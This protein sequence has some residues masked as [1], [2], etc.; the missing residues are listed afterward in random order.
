MKNKN[1]TDDFSLKNIE[2]M[3]MHDMFSFVICWGLMQDGKRHVNKEHFVDF[4]QEITHKSGEK[5]IIAF[6]NSR[7]TKKC[8][9]PKKKMEMFIKGK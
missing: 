2:I 5:L 3:S 8:T 1:I 9:P 7:S 4:I 6:T